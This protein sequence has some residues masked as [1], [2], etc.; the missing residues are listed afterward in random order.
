M[1]IRVQTIIVELGVLL[2][3]VLTFAVGA[4]LVPVSHQVA[5]ANPT[6]TYMRVPL[7]S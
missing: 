4:Y 5:Q 7:A 3:I 1:K 2:A 6:I